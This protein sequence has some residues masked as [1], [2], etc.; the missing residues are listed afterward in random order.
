MTFAARAPLELAV[1][2]HAALLFVL[3]FVLL[4]ALTVALVLAWMRSVR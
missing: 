3:L 4:V 2:R 1:R